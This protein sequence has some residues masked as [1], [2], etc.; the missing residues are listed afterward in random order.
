M[1]KHY[2]VQSLIRGGLEELET[3]SYGPPPLDI[4][5]DL[6]V[7]PIEMKASASPMASFEPLLRKGPTL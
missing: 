7:A 3:L 5:Q 6:G 4:H 1:A 2:G